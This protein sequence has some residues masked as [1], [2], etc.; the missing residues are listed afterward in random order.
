MKKINC[1]V[2]NILIF[3][4]LRK[5]WAA[6][7]PL[8]FVVFHTA[9]SQGQ[10]TVLTV[11]LAAP[12]ANV[13][14]WKYRK[15]PPQIWRRIYHWWEPQYKQHIPI[16]NCAVCCWNNSKIYVVEPLT[17]LYSVICD[18]KSRLYLRSFVRSA[19]KPLALYLLIALRPALSSQ[20]CNNTHRMCRMDNKT[21]TLSLLTRP[22]I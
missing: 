15:Y 18:S 16:L 17:S 19:V 5:P 4:R 8:Q 7:L 12:I 9:A 21:P 1:V 3:T 11:P 20:H 2:V 13:S 14:C 22:M 6:L 10:W